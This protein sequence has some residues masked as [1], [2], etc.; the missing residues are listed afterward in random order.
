MLIGDAGAEV[1]G[2][3][4]GAVAGAKVELRAVAIVV[5]EEQVVVAVVVKVADERAAVFE[6]GAALGY[7][8]LEGDVAEGGGGDL[9][10][11]EVKGEEEKEEEGEGGEEGGGG[12]L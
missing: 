6:A 9:G 10:G 2:Q 7:A 3:S 5:H 1:V 8:G 4:E 11:G 12:A